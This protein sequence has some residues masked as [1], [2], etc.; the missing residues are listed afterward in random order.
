MRAKYTFRAWAVG[1]LPWNWIPVTVCA[2]TYDEA[3]KTARSLMGDGCSLLL[4]SVDMF[5][6]SDYDI[7]IGGTDAD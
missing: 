6:L 2:G 5:N 4:T 7:K 1:Q 3:T